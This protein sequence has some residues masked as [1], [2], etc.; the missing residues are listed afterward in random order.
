MRQKIQ[1]PR[2]R[3]LNDS[4]ASKKNPKMRTC[5]DPCIFPEGQKSV[6]GWFGQ[7]LLK[8]TPYLGRGVLW[9]DVKMGQWLT[10]QEATALQFMQNCLLGIL[11]TAAFAPNLCTFGARCR[12]VWFISCLLCVWAIPSFDE[13]DEIQTALPSVWKR[14]V[15]SSP[16]DNSIKSNA[17]YQLLIWAQSVNVC[18][19]KW[20]TVK[21]N[22]Q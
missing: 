4:R 9:F 20:K 2:G 1:E 3:R 13:L 17:E 18:C 14:Q 6:F 16:F 21:E 15:H 22:V 11:C 5:M 10:K 8:L 12:S 7:D 19:P